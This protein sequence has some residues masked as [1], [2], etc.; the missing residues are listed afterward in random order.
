LAAAA[1]EVILKHDYS[2]SFFSI[3]EGKVNIQVV[4]KMMQQMF[5]R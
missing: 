3:L 1:D 5:S 4:E 2:N